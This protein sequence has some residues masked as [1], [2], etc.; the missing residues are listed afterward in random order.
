M[1]TINSYSELKTAV[2]GLGYQFYEEPFKM[3]IVGLRKKINTNLFDDILFQAFMDDKNT[4]YIQRYSITTDPGK[5]SLINPSNRKG[6]AILSPGQYVDT[7]AI[8]YHRGNYLALCQRL[9]PVTIY[10]DIDKDANHDFNSLQIEKGFFGINLHKAGVL[11]KL[12][13]GWSAGCQVFAKESD[14]NVFMRLNKTHSKRHGNKFTYT[15]IDT[16]L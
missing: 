12:V 4:A 6:T 16:R 8:D 1:I 10:R 11:S 3:N 9:G 5:Q 2:S 15:L 7:Y 14:F 13:D